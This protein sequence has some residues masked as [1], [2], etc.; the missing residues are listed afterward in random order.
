MEQRI[1]VGAEHHGKSEVIRID[2]DAGETYSVVVEHLSSHKCI[3]IDF[4]YPDGDRQ[5]HENI[6]YGSF[7]SVE[8]NVPN[9]M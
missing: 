1:K 4:V 2:I 6:Y 7:E 9:Q 8:G 5:R 3:V